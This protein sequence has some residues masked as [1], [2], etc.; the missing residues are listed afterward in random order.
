MLPTTGAVGPTELQYNQYEDYD[1][2]ATAPGFFAGG[3]ITVPNLRRIF[4]TVDVKRT[5]ELH[6][7]AIKAFIPTDSI[8]G[9]LVQCSLQ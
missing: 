2:G 1:L 6:T 7:H 4:C 5:V 9:L 3:V 8:E